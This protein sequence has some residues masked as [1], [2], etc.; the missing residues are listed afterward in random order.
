MMGWS[1]GSSATIE[2]R[3]SAH[4]AA[5]AAAAAL[6]VLAGCDA[7]EHEHTHDTGSSHT[8]HHDGDHHSLHAHSAGGDDHHNPATW[9]ELPEWALRTAQLH[10]GLGPWAISGAIAGRDARE[11]LTPAPNEVLEVVYKLP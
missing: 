1:Y 4:S 5:V 7:H 2:P 6:C 8:H 3:S 11:R 9:G 10:G